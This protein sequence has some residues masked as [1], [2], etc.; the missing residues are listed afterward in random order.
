MTQIPSKL[1]EYIGMEKPI[2]VISPR[3]GSTSDLVIKES[4]GVTAEPTD[5]QDIASAYSSF[6]GR[7]FEVRLPIK[8]IAMQWRSL[9]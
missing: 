1:F 5:L 9:T 8:L 7:G 2:L 3:G 4:I 6:T